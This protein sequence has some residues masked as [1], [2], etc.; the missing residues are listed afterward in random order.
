MAGAMCDIA[1]D[2][3]WSR[4]CA[5]SATLA[6][7]KANEEELN[8]RGRGIRTA[9]FDAFELMHALQA[10]GV[11]A[12]VAQTAKKTWSSAIRNFAARGH[13]VTLDHAEMGPTVYNGAPYRLSKTP[14]RAAICG[15]ASRASTTSWSFGDM[16]GLAE[17]D[18]AR[19]KAA[20]RL[21]MSDRNLRDVAA[22]V[23]IGHT[24]D[25]P[26]DYARVRRGEKPFDSYGYA[27][28]ALARAIAD[29]GIE[30]R[31]HRRIDRRRHGL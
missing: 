18:L 29:A 3:G 5:S 9:G 30:A 22:I 26:E 17:D 2:Q 21:Q 20:E 1:S 28:T 27:A 12:G 15:A 6:A 8:P 25:W 19:M 10:R 7:R 13:F 23:G 11:P 14:G 4:G 24:C 31:R 16:L